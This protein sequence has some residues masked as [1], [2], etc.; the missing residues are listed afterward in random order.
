MK[1]ELGRAAVGWFSLGLI[2]CLVAIPL[3]P[4]ALR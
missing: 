4:M 1:T 2:G 3:L